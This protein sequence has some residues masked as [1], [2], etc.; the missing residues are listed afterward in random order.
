MGLTGVALLRPS[1]VLLGLKY[2]LKRV[3]EPWKLRS[4]RRFR[5]GVVAVTGE[6]DVLAIWL[7]TFAAEAQERL[8]REVHRW[9]VRLLL[10]Q[11]RR[12][13]VMM[14][15]LLACLCYALSV[16]T[17]RCMSGVRSL[18]G[19]VG[20]DLVLMLPPPTILLRLCD[21]V[22]RHLILM[23][24]RLLQES[25]LVENQVWHCWSVSIT[26][27][28]TLGTGTRTTSIPSCHLRRSTAMPE[29]PGSSLRLQLPSKRLE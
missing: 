7:D 18:S 25:Q 11:G 28:V 2:S 5:P 27:R 6:I 21:I 8:F 19:E 1:V 9:V 15:S 20:R 4:R 22:S 23:V 13:L 17:S 16:V 29:Q 24:L 10:G 14:G 12:M 26:C 3:V